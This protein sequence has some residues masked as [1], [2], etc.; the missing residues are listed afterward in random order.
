MSLASNKFTSILGYKYNGSIRHND[1]RS[2]E[3]KPGSVEEQILAD[4]K[5]DR[6]SD[7]DVLLLIIIIINLVGT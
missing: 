3:I 6:M 4:G 2:A 5:E 7:V 1:G